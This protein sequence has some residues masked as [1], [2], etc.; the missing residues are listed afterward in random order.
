MYKVRQNQG[1]NLRGAMLFWF[2][3][4]LVLQEN[5]EILSNQS[6]ENALE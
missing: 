5:F 3:N 6:P 2:Q 1:E 4:H